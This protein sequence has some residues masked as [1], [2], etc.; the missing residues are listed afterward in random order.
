MRIGMSTKRFAH[1]DQSIWSQADEIGVAGI[2]IREGEHPVDGL[3][4]AASLASRQRV[5]F[6]AV[7][8][9]V[10]GHP[11]HLAE[12]AAVADQVLSG[13]LVLILRGDDSD[14]LAETAGIVTA[15]ARARPVA[16]TN[17]RWP[18]PALLEA[19]SG[20]SWTTVRVTPT[21]HQLRLPVFVSGPG[22]QAAAL[23]T[24]IPYF[25]DVEDRSEGLRVHWEEMRARFG[26]AADNLTRGAIRSLTGFDNSAASTLRSDRQVWGAELVFMQS[27]DAEWTPGT[28]RDLATRLEPRMA[29]D[30]LPVGLTNYW[31]ES[32]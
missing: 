2:L 16:T 5:G 27:D 23:Q 9:S 10:G 22:G 25:A 12:K 3:V 32:Q 4:L 26:T 19:N 30:E 15:A 28:I 1:T 6:V 14:V 29:L 11:I 20:V 7:E 18:T 8:V 31:D 17:G 13:R 21:P 24:A